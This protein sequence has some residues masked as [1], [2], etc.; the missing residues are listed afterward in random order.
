PMTPTAGRPSTST[1]RMMRDIALL[2]GRSTGGRRHGQARSAWPGLKQ[3]PLI[4]TYGWRQIRTW[5]SGL[6][7][8]YCGRRA[9]LVP[10][11]ANAAGG[12]RLTV[13]DAGA[14]G[15]L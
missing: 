8:R 15:R 12:G 2:K 4:I 11:S 7:R 3:L 6:V 14:A 1:Y 10:G 13:A 5:C 9:I